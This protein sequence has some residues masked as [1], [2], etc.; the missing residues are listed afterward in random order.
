MVAIFGEIGGFGLGGDFGASGGKLRSRG[1][2]VRACTAVALALVC[3]GCSG[4]NKSDAAEE[5]D[6]SSGDTAVADGGDDGA[7]GTDSGEPGGFP[8]SPAPFTL[9]LSGDLE[10]ELVFD[11]PDCSHLEGSTSFRQIWRGD[12]HVF[13]L[14]IEMVGTFPEEPAPGSW[15]AAD[16]ARVKLQ[17]E[18]GGS[19]QYAQSAPDD[20]TLVMS[21]EGFDLD[22]DQV[23]G[24]ASVGPLSGSETGTIE[25][26]PQPLPI[27]CDGY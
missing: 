25:L 18:A 1:P 13:V 12:G 19:G 21:I 7:E 24:E 14:I 20:A 27:W 9:T 11:A 2:S 26:A 6:G 23:W 4:D 22:A 15:T 3:I 5:G 8:A 17:E 16:G 10:Q